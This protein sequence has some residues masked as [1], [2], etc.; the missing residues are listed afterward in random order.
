M[1]ATPATEAPAKVSHFKSISFSVAILAG[2]V[3][4]LT[5]RP[6]AIPQPAHLV[7]AIVATTVILWA[8][9]TINNGI[10]SVLMMGLMIAARVP[11]PRVLSGF[12]DGAFWTLLTVL[13]YGFAMKKTRLAERIAYHLLA[14]FPGTYS[15]VLSAFFLIGL[16][17][18]LGIPSMTV[19]T[20][21]MTPIAWALVQSLGLA[22]RSRGAA[23]IM[24]TTVEMAVVPGIAFLYGSLA[25]P[26]VA[27]SFAVKHLELTWL[28][29][30]KVTTLPTLLLCA[31]I[32]VGNQML[33]RPEEPL[34][35]SSKFAKL[36]LAELGSLKLPELITAIVV[37][38]SIIFWITT[39]FGLPSFL[40]G[41]LA[42]PVFALAGIL[43]DEDI[44]TGV[45]WQLLLF[46]GGIFGLANVIADYKITDW[47]AQ[48]LIPVI[49]RLAAAPLL[50]VLA[51]AVA[52]F[53][54]RFVDPSSFIA[55]AVLF[56]AVVDI[57]SRA[58]V[59]PLVTMS[60][61]MLASV[62]FWMTYQNFWLALGDG[63][64]GN[65]AF[66]GAQRIRLAHGYAI[67]T[68]VALAVSVGYWKWIGVL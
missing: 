15:G 58:G 14:I 61:L 54:F 55:I 48:F 9:Q 49:G 57:T 66:T 1:I 41:M 18:T 19:R 6:P 21:I 28:G 34:R 27:H 65:Q 52:M 45:S 47:F 30:A 39:P 29:Y 22:P 44:A 59:P 2:L 13:F 56:L 64:T 46:V 33:M 7:L 4:A 11:V 60:A 43:R 67:F 35:A 36:R 26:V 20:A 37:G 25:G 23:L 68:L 3:I 51:L 53:A 10:A 40:V 8:T 50:L 24:I 12:S 42:L 38:L 31:L 16:L 32:L 62:P 17:L 5:P 63:L